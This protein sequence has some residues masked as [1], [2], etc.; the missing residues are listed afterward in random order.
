[1]RNDGTRYTWTL[2]YDPQGA[3]GRGQIVFT[4]HGDAP[5][6]EEV[7]KPNLP[8]NF[9]KE[10]RIRFPSNTTFTIDLPEGYKE[11]GTTFD[12]FGL[13]NMTK[14]GGSI[15]IHFDDLH[16]LGRSQDFSKDPG[17]D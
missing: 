3:A 14:P 6:P 8:E 2:D 5:K 12:H 15:T 11:H 7:D 1:I 9:H 13:M 4:I 16:Y 17:W 10:A